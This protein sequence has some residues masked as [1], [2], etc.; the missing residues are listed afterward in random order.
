MC[1]NYRVLF[2][3][4][5]QLPYLNWDEDSNQI[6]LLCILLRILPLFYRSPHIHMLGFQ[7]TNSNL[8]IK[9][10]IPT[11]FLSKNLQLLA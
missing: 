8:F 3:Y 9:I 11:L 7:P 4:K 10:F 1:I 5:P 2:F 6:L